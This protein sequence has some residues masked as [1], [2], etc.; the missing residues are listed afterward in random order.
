MTVN[1]TDFNYK[2]KYKNMKRFIEVFCNVFCLMGYGILLQ[3][4][5]G[6][7]K[8]T[9][10][11]FFC[12]CLFTVQLTV[13]YLL[14]ISSIQYFFLVKEMNLKLHLYSFKYIYLF[15]IQ[16]NA[17]STFLKPCTVIIGYVRLFYLVKTSLPIYLSSVSNS[18]S[19]LSIFILSK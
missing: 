8:Y 9:F 14:C 12:C 16:Y 13:L 5:S 6:Y 2:L 10:L 18:N 11:I 19:K 3:T 15:I 4:A 17:Y 7:C 1:F